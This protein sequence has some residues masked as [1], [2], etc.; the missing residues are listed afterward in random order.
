LTPFWGTHIVSFQD[1]TV[2][3]A[4][5][6]L[7]SFRQRKASPVRAT[8][9]RSAPLLVRKAHGLWL[10]GLSHG[11][12]PLLSQARTLGGNLLTDRLVVLGGWW[13]GR[14]SVQIRPLEAGPASNRSW[15][16][17]VGG[18]AASSFMVKHSRCLLCLATLVETL[19]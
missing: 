19:R 4:R 5:G 2:P 6:A 17:I 12:C 18:H 9:R 11:F 13:F 14:L 8:G 15:P 16:P 7:S 10:A 1:V 3:A